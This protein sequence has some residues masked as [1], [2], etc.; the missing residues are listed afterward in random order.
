MEDNFSRA[1]TELWTTLQLA[2]SIESACG[3]AMNWVL[4]YIGYTN[5]GIW[6]IDEDGEIVLSGQVNFTVHDMQGLQ[7]VLLEKF[8]KPLI[9]ELPRIRINGGAEIEPL[10]NWEIGSL[11]GMSISYLDS[12]GA[13]V[14]LFREKEPF[15]AEDADILELLDPLFVAQCADITNNGG[16]KDSDSDSKPKRDAS[17]WWKLGEEPPY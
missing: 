15:T 1:R 13:V 12:P 6:N 9:L 8:V 16:E 11:L 14:L 2:K 17:Y 10:A 7:T 3:H 5:I 4:R